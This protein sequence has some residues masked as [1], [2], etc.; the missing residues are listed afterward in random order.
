MREQ[1]QAIFQSLP[2]EGVAIHG[3]NLARAKKIRKEG[4]IPQ[5]LHPGMPLDRTFYTLQVPNLNP[6]RATEHIDEL[7]QAFRDAY[8]KYAIRAASRPLYKLS[9]D[10]ASHIPAILVFRPPTQ[11]DMNKH[12]NVTT[13]FPTVASYDNP[14][15]GENVYGIIPVPVY[16]GPNE[17]ISEAVRIL[18]EKGVIDSVKPRQL[19]EA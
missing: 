11:I 18:V 5:N 14:I 13:P 19:Q 16:T 1:M 6:T 8:T 7:K 10:P 17:L 3:T 15:P 12:S 9:E 4:F 2:P